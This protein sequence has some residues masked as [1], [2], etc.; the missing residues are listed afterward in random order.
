LPLGIAPFRITVYGRYGRRTADFE[1]FSEIVVDRITAGLNVGIGE[2]LVAKAEYLVNREISGAPQVD[3]N[4][5]TSS[6]VW[7]W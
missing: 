7:T 2:N 4:V 1:G 3:N 5:M 6:V